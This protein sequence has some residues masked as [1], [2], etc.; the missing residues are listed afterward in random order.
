MKVRCWVF[1][2]VLINIFA[3]CNYYMCMLLAVTIWIFSWIRGNVPTCQKPFRSFVLLIRLAYLL[4]CIVG[5]SVKFSI[6][7]I[8]VFGLYFVVISL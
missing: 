4:P 1:I 2:N 7:C 6:V 3:M 5:L 8:Q